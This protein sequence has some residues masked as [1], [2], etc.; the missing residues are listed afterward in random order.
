[1]PVIRRVKKSQVSTAPAKGR[2]IQKQTSKPAPKRTARGSAKVTT[3]AK[4]STSKPKSERQVDPVTG[5]GVGTDSDI[6]IKEAMRGGNTRPEVVE[7]IK[8][9]LPKE[10]ASGSEKPVS[11]VFASVL[12]KKL[13][14]GYYIES[15]WKLCPPTPASKRKMT[16]AKKASESDG[17]NVTHIASKKRVTTRAGRKK[18][19]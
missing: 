14:Q 17:E 1:M 18:V 13:D 2:A 9:R 12:K 15:S 7:R 8:E 16:M 11:N 10:T 6:M 19:A 3:V 4:P 5:F